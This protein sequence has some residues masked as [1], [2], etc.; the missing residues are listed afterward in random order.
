IYGALPLTLLYL[1]NL[2]LV[3]LYI[4]NL[5]NDCIFNADGC[6]EGYEI[7][8]N[9]FLLLALFVTTILLLLTAF[10]AFRVFKLTQTE[11]SAKR[12]LIPRTV[13]IIAPLIAASLFLPILNLSR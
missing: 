7:P 12:T 1:L 3:K 10:N 5:P 8:D 4:L 11:S 2:A 9:P 6:P 13:V